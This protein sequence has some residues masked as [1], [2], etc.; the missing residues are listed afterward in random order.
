MLPETNRDK[1][2]TVTPSRGKAV[3]EVLSVMVNAAQC[4]KSMDESDISEIELMIIE[5]QI[6]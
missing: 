6:N 3:G 4:A 5:Y 1:S 2:T